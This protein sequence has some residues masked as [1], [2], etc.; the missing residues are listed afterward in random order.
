MRIFIPVTFAFLLLLSGC[1]EKV[2]EENKEKVSSPQQSIDLT[3]IVLKDTSDSETIF[4]IIDDKLKLET[5][6][7]KVVLIN[8]FTTW[9][10]PCRAQI[11]HL[12]NLNS[13]Y[14]DK[15]EI[16]T[17]LLEEKKERSELIDF[18]NE[19]EIAFKVISSEQNF[20]LANKLGGVKSIPYMLI[21]DKKGEYFKHYIGAIPEEMIEADL[22]KVM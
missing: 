15:L 16:I 18:I 13:K 4:N 12:N 9:C 17:I 10:P 19:N 20:R 8:F 22:K 3:K 2:T 1:S 11:P 5:Y 21:Y 7:G 6:Q 14:Q